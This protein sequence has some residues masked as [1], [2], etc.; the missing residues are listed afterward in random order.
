M[1]VRGGEVEFHGFSRSASV[2]RALRVLAENVPGVERVAHE[3][4]EHPAGQGD[5]AVLGPVDGRYPLG[6]P[7]EIQL[8]VKFYF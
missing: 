4:A 6:D 7:R 1:N 5:D 8:A 3:Q 2:Q